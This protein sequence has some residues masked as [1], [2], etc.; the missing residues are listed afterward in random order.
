MSVMVNGILNS[1]IGLLCSKL[2]D[3][4]AEKLDDGDLTDATCRQ[5]IVRELDDIKS[6]LDGLS[7]K[8]LLASLR[9]FEE[10]V[11]GLYISLEKSNHYDSPS[12]SKEFIADEAEV[13]GASAVTRVDQLSDS[14]C[15]ALETAS[16]LSRLVENLKIASKERYKY[17]KNSLNEARILATEVFNNVAL[18]TEDRIMASKLC[19]ASRILEGLDDTEAAVQDCLLYLKELHDLP[20]VQSM[21][22]VWLGSGKGITSNLR[23]RFNKTKRNENIESIQII[24]A[25]LVHFVIKFE[26]RS[27]APFNWPQ[28][29]TIKRSYHPLLESHTLI[30]K[31][32]EENVPWF[33]NMRD[34]Y[35]NWDQCALTSKGEFLSMT[36]NDRL[37][38]IRNDGPKLFF[39]VNPENNA[40]DCDIEEQNPEKNDDHAMKEIC[41]FAVDENDNV[42]VVIKITS[43]SENVLIRY[44]LLTLNANQNVKADRF[45]KLIDK[46]LKGAVMKLTKNGKLVIYDSVGGNMFI[47]DSKNAEYDYKFPLTFIDERPGDFDL[48][49][50][51][52]SNKNEII[53]TLITD[54]GKSVYMYIVTIDGKLIR[55]VQVPGL[56]NSLEYRF[57]NAIFNHV[58]ETILISLYGDFDWDNNNDDKNRRERFKIGKLI[59]FP[60]KKDDSSDS[61]SDSDDN[62]AIDFDGENHTTLFVFSNTGELLNE[63]KILGEYDSMV[64]HEKGSIFLIE[65]LFDKVY[66]LQA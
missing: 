53:L 21:F 13:H 12:T 5:I 55:V 44:K 61:D 19:I 35:V 50:L 10:G 1:T 60:C 42:Y 43:V 6:K 17:A 63:F 39:T 33:W 59:S 11:T 3:F 41:C 4:T 20:A 15:E 9:F 7:R 28:I 56:N 23:T 45:L 64:S 29:Q 57:V 31:I 54:N 8:D 16:E 62:S 36:I 48:F 40:E 26:V 14:K 30:R 66:M 37:E 24:N 32:S 65:H 52:I 25:A 27:K 22:S 34:Q 49:S 18:S 58:N 46:Q 38:I 51:N 47:C 2:R